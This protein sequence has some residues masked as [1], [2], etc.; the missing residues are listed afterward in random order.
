[1]LKKGTGGLDGRADALVNVP[2]ISHLSDNPLAPLIC[3][4]EFP[5]ARNEPGLADFRTLTLH[6]VHYAHGP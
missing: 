4:W 6:F 1:M 3:F 5:K 2:G